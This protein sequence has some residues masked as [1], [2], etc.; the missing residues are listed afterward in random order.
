MFTA[1][2][3]FLDR[4]EQSFIIFKDNI[5]PLTVPLL[6]FNFLTLVVLP[7]FIMLLFFV[8]IPLE[9]FFS[10]GWD[11]EAFSNISLIVTFGITLWFLLTIIYIICLIPIQVAIIKTIKNSINGT[12]ESIQ[13]TL[14]YGIKRIFDIF[15]VYWYIFAYTLLLPACVFIVWGIL[16]NIGLYYNTSSTEVLTLVWGSLM[17]VSAIFALFSMIYRWTKATFAWVSA[18]DSESFYKD[19]FLYSV[20]ITDGKWWRVFW[21]VFGVA[22]IWT[23]VIGIVGGLWESIAFLGNDWEAISEIETEQQEFQHLI[24]SFTDFNILFF[25]NSIIQTFLNT[26]LGVFVSVYIYVYYKRLEFEA[27][28]NQKETTEL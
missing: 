12:Q 26:V 13:D 23:L 15:R 22:I 18:V 4:I 19:N 1:K 3:S 20:K 21:N 8:I 14:K 5:F 10:Q 17:W 6:I 16:L 9:S 27:R 7:Y 28:S 25:I 11:I 24:S 2:E